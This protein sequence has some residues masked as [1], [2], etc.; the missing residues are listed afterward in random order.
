MT[1][2]AAAETLLEIEAIKRLKARYFRTMDTKDWAGF[3]AVFADDASIDVT[4]DAGEAGIVEGGD[5][6]AAFIEG[7]VG[8][9]TTVHHGHMPEITL[10]GP[11]TATG[12]W[13]MYDYVEMPSEEGRRGLHGYGHYHETYVKRGDEWRIASM[14]LSRLRVDP[15]G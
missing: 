8:P 15:L 9:A 2:S 13:A 7:A 6:I 4:E 11:G 12:V 1:S 10:T 5:A 14:K 3:R